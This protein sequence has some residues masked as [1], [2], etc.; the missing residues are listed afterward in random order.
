MDEL[1]DLAIGAVAVL[2]GAA[3][4]AGLLAFFLAGAF[5]PL[6]GVYVLIGSV[7]F[8]VGYSV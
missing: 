3:L 8:I 5:W 7:A 4:F 1:V 2:V 6:F